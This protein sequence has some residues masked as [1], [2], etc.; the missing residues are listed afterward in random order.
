MLE[1]GAH[2]ANNSSD[3]NVAVTHSIFFFLSLPLFCVWVT[4]VPCRHNRLWVNREHTHTN[5]VHIQ[6]I[7][8]AFGPNVEAFA[9]ISFTNNRLDERWLYRWAHRRQFIFRLL[10]YTAPDR[11]HISVII[12]VSHFLTL[13]VRSKSQSITSECVNWRHILK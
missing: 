6:S 3:E 10:V 11:H 2:R 1:H 9:L 8:K 7:E 13:T 12:F 4:D 5:N